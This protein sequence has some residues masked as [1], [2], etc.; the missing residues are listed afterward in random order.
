MGDSNRVNFAL[1]WTV[2]D[3]SSEVV[4]GY[5]LNRANNLDETLEAIAYWDCPPQNFAIATRS[6]EIAQVVQGKYPLK[7]K[8]QGKF[9]M[10]GSDPKYEWQGFIPDDHNA[11]VVNPERG[12]ISSANQHPFSSDYP[13]YYHCRSEEH[14]RNKRINS[15]LNAASEVTA[16]DMKALQN[17]NYFTLASESLPVMLDSLDM[18]ELSEDQKKIVQLLKGWDYMADAD[19]TEPSYFH[20]WWMKM[21][22]MLWDE[23]D[24]DIPV[25]WPSKHKTKEMLNRFPT[26]SV[27][28][29]G[30]TPGIE[31]IND[32]LT[33]SFIQGIDSVNAWIIANGNSEPLWYLFKNTRLLH[34][35]RIKSFSYFN[36][37]VGG[38]M[39]IINATG[40]DW[41]A[42]WRMVVELGDEIEAWGI[43]PGGQSGNPGSPAYNNFIADWAKGEY[44]KIA[45]WSTFD[46][47]R[48]GVTNFILTKKDLEED[49]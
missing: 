4:A 35:T 42:S 6:G 49:N 24:M 46:A 34:M 15:I 1:K 31:T 28:D 2:H 13:Y 45:F 9:I 16:E 5:N 32:I 38:Y 11:K 33:A 30:D 37:P 26:D 10:D 14:F 44:F 18:G 25:E 27:F 7:W 12:F 47:D 8:E 23:F 22:K 36:I 17:D 29:I 48:E 41:G 39:G 40:H 3:P 20:A 19:V 43:Y 21:Y